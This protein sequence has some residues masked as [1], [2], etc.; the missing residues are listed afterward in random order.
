ML[1]QCIESRL[2]YYQQSLSLF[3]AS[4]HKFK[5][6]HSISNRPASINSSSTYSS[7]GYESLKTAAPLYILDASFNPPTVAHMRMI[8]HSGL[9]AGNGSIATCQ[10]RLLL[11]LAVKNADKP[12]QRASLDHRLSMMEMFCSDLLLNIPENQRENLKIDIGIISSPYFVDK[13]N[14][15]EA[16]GLYPPDME[17]IYLI[18]FDT[19]ARIM[20]PQ[21]YPPNYTLEKLQSPL[22]K[23]RFLVFYRPGDKY[24]SESEQN[25]YLADIANG[26]L[27]AVAG[28]RDWVREGRI[29]LHE[30]S[31]CTNCD[32]EN[33]ISSTKIRDIIKQGDE[34]LIK[35]SL[36]K[37]LTVCVHEW[38][39][40]NRLYI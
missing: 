19:L 21:Y 35:T 13:M 4:S 34:K 1:R 28:Q 9:F 15:I 33:I 17:H 14:T 25:T 22:E 30:V 6:V 2:S 18:G 23:H 8:L 26:S 39:G 29:K 7:N 10:S 5:I 31:N 27:D 37:I 40:C 3:S 36:G 11:L 32:N 24:G 20:N 12:P 16:S 38:I